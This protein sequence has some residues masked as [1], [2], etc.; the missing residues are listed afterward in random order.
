MSLV[1]I[2]NWDVA[3]GLTLCELVG[4]PFQW[5]RTDCGTLCRITLDSLYGSGRAAELLGP[6]W[7]SSRAALKVWT[8]VGGPLAVLEQ[9]GAVQ[10]DRSY[11]SI[12]DVIV[13]SGSDED[14]LP[15]LAVVAGPKYV[16]VTRTEG[17]LAEPV[18]SLTA[19]A[20]IWR[21]P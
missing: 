3:L 7:K 4:T 14:G 6:A 2:R 9:I 15:R 10:M 8:R 16:R 1:R 19:D 12:G 11:A 5:G 20:A 17:V 18:R 21:L 13:I